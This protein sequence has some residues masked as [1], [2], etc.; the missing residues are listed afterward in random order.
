MRDR[1]GAPDWNPEDLKM[2]RLGEHLAAPS[3]VMR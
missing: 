3:G 1:L 2:I